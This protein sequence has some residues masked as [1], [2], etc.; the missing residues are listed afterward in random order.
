MDILTGAWVPVRQ[1]GKITH[2]TIAEAEKMPTIA[3]SNNEGMAFSVFM[4]LL[5]LKYCASPVKTERFMQDERAKT[6][7]VM[8]VRK[9]LLDEPGDNT[10][11]H[12]KDHF[13]KRGRDVGF[14][15]CCAVTG[16]YH[17]SQFSGAGGAGHYPGQLYQNILCIRTGETVGDTLRLNKVPVQPNGAF[18]SASKYYW[19]DDPADEGDC[20]LC[21]NHAPLIR[22]YFMQKLTKPA[23]VINPYSVRTLNNKRY[24]LTP[25][26]SDLDILNACA[27][28]SESA[29]PPEVITKKSRAGDTVLA[30]GTCYDNAKFV[31]KQTKYFTLRRYVELEPILTTTLGAMRRVLYGERDISYKTTTLVSLRKMICD[32]VE[33]G[34]PVDAACQEVYLTLAPPD[35]AP[36]KTLSRFVTGMH[37]IEKRARQWREQRGISQ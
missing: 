16:L 24:M 9:L 35:Q 7:Q 31:L 28:D 12:N 30:F 15:A 11:K 17:N 34:M 29:I 19:L 10:I 2:H 22:R 27:P 13:V 3:I 25:E 26:S 8:H 14:C 20:W 6:G 4:I 21:G 1:N 36:L 37:R 23:E 5:G 32:R 18:F 33:N